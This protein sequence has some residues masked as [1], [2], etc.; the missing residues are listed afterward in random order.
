MASEQFDLYS[1]GMKEDNLVRKQ[2]EDYL[3]MLHDT[4]YLM[5]ELKQV[6]KQLIQLH[7]G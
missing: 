4:E 2:K 3:R 5:K 7:L 1:R 6:E